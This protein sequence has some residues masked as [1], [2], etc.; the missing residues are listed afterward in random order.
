MLDHALQLAS[1]DASTELEAEAGPVLG[2]VLVTVL[3]TMI[4]FESVSVLTIVFEPVPVETA[5]VLA[6][7]HADHVL[8]PSLGYTVTVIHW[9][10]VEVTVSV[11]S[12]AFHVSGSLL[13][14]T[15]GVLVD[16]HWLHVAGSLLVVAAGVLLLSHA[17]QVAGSSEVVLV[18]TAG[19]LLEEVHSL[20]V[21]GSSLV[22]LSAGVDEL[23]HALQV[24]LSESGAVVLGLLEVVSRT[25]VFEST[26][27]VADASQPSAETEPISTAAAAKVVAFIMSFDNDSI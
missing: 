15:A 3:E 21:A 16:C 19:V 1:L 20:Q 25:G 26:G 23:V 11:G 6:D 2:A 27:S 8:L 14:T 9:V 13:V 5:G 4:V 10:L 22:V 24:W 12:H 18:L 17:L 7:D